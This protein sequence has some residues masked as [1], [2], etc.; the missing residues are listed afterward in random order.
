MSQIVVDTNLCAK[1]G[2]CVAVCPAGALR[3][4][5]QNVPEKVPGSVC[6]LCGHCV[7]VCPTEAI[8]H[9]GLPKGEMPEL[10]RELPNAA[11]MD[12]LL[13]GRRSVREFKP[14]P[15][16]RSTVEAL[17]DVARR[18]PS[19]SNSQQL[20]WIV[21]PDA[22]KVRA[23]SAL[24]VDWA[25][26][27]ELAF[28]A[29][30]IERWESGDDLILRGAPT[31]VVAYAPAEYIFGKVD[32]AIALTYLEL[33]AEARGLGACWAGFLTVAGQHESLRRALA[34]PEDYA[35][36]GGMMLGHPKYRYRR[37]PPR[38]PIRVDWL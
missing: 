6:I 8:L 4:N 22:A 1:D 7:A 21:V 15:L 29:R 23:I 20:R 36:C 35:V 37:V 26:A 24:V 13:L 3:S 33:A 25:R 32:S 16:E 17:L 9:R 34:V 10:C 11:Q 12:G 19:A 38:N 30:A 5:E 31:V 18:A 28:A 2:M 27:T 14:E